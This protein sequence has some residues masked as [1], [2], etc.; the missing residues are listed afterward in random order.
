LARGQD[1]EDDGLEEAGPVRNQRGRA[2]RDSV[3]NAG[4]RGQRNGGGDEEDSW[5]HDRFEGRPSGLANA[6]GAAVG[7]GARLEA[8]TKVL[9]SNLD[10]AVGAEDIKEIFQ[11]LGSVVKAVVHY[12]QDRRSLGSAEVQFGNS[13]TATKAVT[14]YDGAEVDGRPMYLK[15]IGSL[16]VAPVSR[17][18]QKRR[19]R[20]VAPTGGTARREKESFFGTTRE[21]RRDREDRGD[22]PRRGRGGSRG[23]S[24]GERRG[25][26]A[27]G[28]RGGRGG[29]R[30]GKRNGDGGD[31]KTPVDKESLD[32]EMDSWQSNRGGAA[33]PAAAAG[34]TGQPSGPAAAAE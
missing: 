12:D 34:S 30:G 9:V 8:G 20:V 14:E 4:A 32:K 31:D 29:G 27:A 2:A 1:E 33:A 19:D 21:D 7:G 26:G 18:V 16:I 23:G 15:V 11:N 13:A 24:T 25:R 22:R 17:V 10:P 28:S 5:S 3:P 6:P